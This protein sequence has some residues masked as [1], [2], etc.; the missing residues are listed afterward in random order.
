M[1]KKIIGLTLIAMSF[2]AFSG[3]AQKP[4]NCPE[5]CARQENCARPEKC[6][7]PEKCD[8]MCPFE[9][10]NLTDAQKAQLQ[11]L[12][13]ECRATAQKQSQLRKENKMRNDSAFIAQRKAAKKAYLK[14]VKDII[15][16]DQYIIFLENMYVNGGSP[17]HRNGTGIHHPKFNKAKGAYKMKRDGKDI[18]RQQRQMNKSTESSADTAT[19]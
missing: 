15:G 18:R 14:Q 10:L 17:M 3:M 19:K 1:K 2:I 13:S 9:G 6:V 16:P 12:N 8:R 4:A 11:K 7:G 5:N